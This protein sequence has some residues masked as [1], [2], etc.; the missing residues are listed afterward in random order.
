MSTVIPSKGL[1]PKDSK[2][3][4]EIEAATAALIKAIVAKVTK[5]FDEAKKL[6]EVKKVLNTI[7]DKWNLPDFLNFYPRET[8]LDPNSELAKR[9][10]RLLDRHSA[11]G[12]RIPKFSEPNSNIAKLLG[13]AK[14]EPDHPSADFGCDFLSSP[15]PLFRALAGGNPEIVQELLDRGADPNQLYAQECFDILFGDVI[16]SDKAEGDKAGVMVRGKGMLKQLVSAGFTGQKTGLIYHPAQL[17]PPDED[18]SL[19]LNRLNRGMNPGTYRRDLYEEIL[20]TFNESL[21]AK[22]TYDKGM[23]KVSSEVFIGILPTDSGK[24]SGTQDML[25]SYTG[26]KHSS[27]SRATK[28]DADE[29]ADEKNQNLP[30][31]KTQTSSDNTKKSSD[32]EGSKP[33]KP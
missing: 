28:K 12:N 17:Y 4:Q 32:E 5:D 24:Y 26:T 27:S 1:Q 33:A 22:D 25:H 19:F 20:K 31:S 29:D 6:E 16:E 10:P 15:N 7:N 13:Y 2:E 14:N 8:M 23:E 18:N 21:G 3:L 30:Q 11:M 9:I